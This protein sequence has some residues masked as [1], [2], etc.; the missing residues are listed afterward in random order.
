[1]LVAGLF[2]AVLAGGGGQ[3]CAIA[4]V[5]HS[6]DDL[7]RGCD[8][9]IVIYSHTAVE[10]VDADLAHAVHMGDRFLHVC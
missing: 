5:H 10:Q 6:G 2:L 3:F 8:R 9:F 1:M 7:V 4:A